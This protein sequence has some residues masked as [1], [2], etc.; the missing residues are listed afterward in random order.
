[1]PIGGFVVDFACLKHR[2]IVELDGG[3]HTRAASSAR[4]HSR[5]LALKQLGFQVRRFWNAEV[6]ANIDDV[7]ETILFDI[8]QT[9]PASL[10]S[11]PSPEREGKLVIRSTAFA[12]ALLQHQNKK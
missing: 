6:Q 9:P 8:R 4:D 2:L 11:A 7:V 10:R 12:P 1:V 3:G 5:D